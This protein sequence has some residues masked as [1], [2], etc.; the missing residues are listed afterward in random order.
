MPDKSAP[1]NPQWQYALIRA[2][3]AMLFVLC[4]ENE[5]LAQ[6]A[7]EAGAV[8]GL[9]RTCEKYIS[10]PNVVDEVRSLRC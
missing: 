3:S 9:T 1:S 7:V 10:A 5:A 4:A 8:E 2:A 6:R